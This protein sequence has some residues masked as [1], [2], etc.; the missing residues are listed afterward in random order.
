MPETPYPR[1]PGYA[2][3]YRDQR[4]RS[5]SG[6][7]TD[8]RERSVLRNLLAAGQPAPGP[9]LD[10]PCG[11][12]RMTDELPG[13]CVQVDRD[14]NMVR[15]CSN[16][17]ARACASVHALPFADRAFAGVLCHRLLQHIPTRVERIAI[18]RELA[19]VTR[20]PI[21]V[22]FFDACSLQHL[23][24]LLRRCLGKRRSSRT[25]VTRH[26]FLAELRD[27]GLLPVAVRAL[28]R[29]IAEQTLVL[30]ERPPIR[31]PHSLDSTPSP[32]R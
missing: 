5:G 8:R 20:G 13:P 4:F 26:A 30:C 16:G 22:S 15:A 17:H 29:F 31:S 10:A 2:Q 23:R 27:A 11:A 3:R 18:L 9:W 21:V 1:E 12:G 6:E 28:Q 25:A 7:G 32:R 24:R 14:P 19:R